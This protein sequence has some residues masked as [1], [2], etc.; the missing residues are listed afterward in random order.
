[1]VEVKGNVSQKVLFQHIKNAKALILYSRF[2]TFGCANRSSCF[3]SACNS[4]DY[5]VFKEIVIPGVNGLYGG[6]NNPNY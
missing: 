4:L 2:E 5:P 3:R 1:M 6:N